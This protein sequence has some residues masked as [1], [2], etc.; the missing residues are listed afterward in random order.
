MTDFCLP[1]SIFLLTPFNSAASLE[2]STD[3]L[4]PVRN[5]AAGIIVKQFFFKHLVS[6]IDEKY[7]L[8]HSK[9]NIDK[10]DIRFEDVF[11]E[12]FGR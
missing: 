4:Q 12:T 6:F 9:F 5:E 10:N 11:M 2:A 7:A 8:E 1:A 3:N